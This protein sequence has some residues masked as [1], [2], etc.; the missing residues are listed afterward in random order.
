M[1]SVTRYALEGIDRQPPHD[2]LG[3][4]TAMV[5]LMYDYR[6]RIPPS[7]SRD[8]VF[9]PPSTT[10]VRPPVQ[11]VDAMVGGVFRRIRRN[12]QS[13][14]AS[15]LVERPISGGG[16]FRRNQQHDVTGRNDQ[17]ARGQARLE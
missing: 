9:L 14:N 17:S 5:A 16:H 8:S 13:R 6:Q 2:T 3:S 15:A 12:G 4:F 7:D 11:T 1:P 10:S